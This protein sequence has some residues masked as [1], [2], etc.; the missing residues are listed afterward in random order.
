MSNPTDDLPK[1]R[2][3]VGIAVLTVS[4]TRTRETDTSGALLAARIE[5]QGHRLAARQIVPDDA[6]ILGPLLDRWTARDDV[7]VILTT[8]GT[9]ITGRDVTVDTVSERLTRVIPGFG[10]L[11]RQLSYEEIGA[12]TIQSR[13]LGGLAGTTFIFAL[14]GSTGACRTAWD[15]ILSSQLNVDQ[16]PCNLVQLMPRLNEQ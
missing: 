1:V 5:G 2:Q 16:R 6:A 13:A 3:A 10:E 8:G 7:D 15:R 11:F 14:P 9:G 4:D 12:S